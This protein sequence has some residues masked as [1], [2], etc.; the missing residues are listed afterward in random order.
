MITATMERPSLWQRIKQLFASKFMVILAIIGLWGVGINTI[1]NSA[2]A[3]SYY[4]FGTVYQ[5]FMLYNK[6]DDV[7]KD[8]QKQKVASMGNF[9]S[10]GVSGTFS[11]NDIVNGVSGSKKDTAKK[12]SSMMATY[13]TFGYISNFIQGF[14]SIPGSLMRIVSLILLVPLGFVTDVIGAIL[15]GLINLLA[16]F[17]V[18]VLLGS[19]FGNLSG[20]S[21]LA[22]AIG[23]SKDTMVKFMNTLISFNVAAILIALMITFKH[24]SSNIDQR[25]A[26]KLKGRLM[27]WIGL[28]LVVFAGAYV[29]NSITDLAKQETTLSE[30]YARYMI[31]VRNWAYQFNFAPDGN[32]TNASGGIEMGKN[33]SFVDLSFNPYTTKG[34]SRIKNINALSSLAGNNAVLKNSTLALMY[35]TGQYFSASDYIA[36]VGSKAAEDSMAA[37]SY[38]FIAN[39]YSDHLADTKNAYEGN[40]AMKLDGGNYT[41]DGPYKSAKDDYIKKDKLITSPQIAWRDRFIYGSKTGGA[42][43]DDYY[44]EAPSWEQVNNTVGTGESANGKNY[45]LSDQSMFLAL[46]TIF[47]ENGGRYYIDAPARGVMQAKSAFDSNR[48]QYY[49]VSMVGNPFFTIPGM[50]AEPLIE[51]IALITVVLAVFSIGLVEMNTKPFSAFVKGATLGDFEYPEAFLIYTVGIAGTVIMLVAV[52]KFLILALKAIGKTLMLPATKA[53]VTPQASLIA[54]GTPQLVSCLVS[55]IVAIMFWKVERFRNGL[56]DLYTLPWAWAKSSGE[57]LERQANPGGMSMRREQS[58]MRDKNKLNAFATTTSAANSEKIRNRLV[59]LAKSARKNNPD[60]KDDQT[61]TPDIPTDTQATQTG[62]TMEQLQRKTNVSHATETLRDI[63]NE[64]PKLSG[65]EAKAEEDLQQ[66][67]DHPTKRNLKNAEHSLAELRDNVAPEDREKIDQ[68]IQHLY[69]NDKKGDVGPDN[70]AE[71]KPTSDSQPTTKHSESGSEAETAG[72]VKQDGSGEPLSAG[73]DATGSNDPL[74]V[75]SENGSQAEKAIDINSDGTDT[76]SSADS[77]DNDS[78]AP[79][80]VKSEGGAEAEKASDVKNDGSEA[81]LATDKGAES[82]ASDSAN[83]SNGPVIVKSGIGSQADSASKIVNDGNG[84]NSDKAIDIKSD[85]SHDQAIVS[86]AGDNQVNQPTSASSV[87]ASLDGKVVPDMPN[88]KGSSAD[89]QRPLDSGIASAAKRVVTEHVHDN[90]NSPHSEQPTKVV[91]VNHHDQNVANDNRATTNENH[92]EKHT[93]S[94]DQRRT[95]NET[96]TSTHNDHHSSIDRRSNVENHLNNSEI[97]TLYHQ[98]AQRLETS[99]GRSMSNPEVRAAY[100]RIVNSKDN[101]ALR[102]GVGLLNKSFGNLDK[103]TL[104]SVNQSKTIKSLKDMVRLRSGK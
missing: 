1:N 21:A 72:D 7:T 83:G 59:A 40:L 50:M 16:K 37:G 26:R 20:V 13:S 97:R 104:S 101:T 60:E 41:A 89:R 15:P 86:L 30:G 12:F 52:P 6:S 8:A 85:G 33:G 22:E 3:D 69:G 45:G 103:N 68:A 80:V 79:V 65:L 102:E 46:S 56:I 99:L 74:I 11:Y 96:H 14:E 2:N 90:S 36:Y 88:E 94:Q 31:D 25:G 9:G 58:E 35:G 51:V 19:F 53:A 76:P 62:Q 17:N 70:N 18:V 5:Y 77:G 10:G 42:K 4:Q 73:D 82:T 55:L 92:R 61:G 81:S 63:N 44:G 38:Y 34:G 84:E 43:I 29:I 91:N 93:V 24:G 57:R 75:K 95:M 67:V 49:S 48:S 66:Y 64:D 23:I 47:N 100:Q 87:A 27:T 28:P 54:Q 71:P 78:T 32:N 98:S 39:T